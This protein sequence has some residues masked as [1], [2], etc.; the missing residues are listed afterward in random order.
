MLAGIGFR[1][2]ELAGFVVL[3]VTPGETVAN[4]FHVHEAVAKKPIRANSTVKSKAMPS[5][6]DGHRFL[7]GDLPDLD[8]NCGRI[9]RGLCRSRQHFL[10]EHANATRGGDSQSHFAASHAQDGQFDLAIN[11]NFF[12][13][14]TAQDEHRF[15][16]PQHD[17]KRK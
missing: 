4:H 17:G 15:S 3:H 8:G 1:S 9:G 6:F 13:D 10:A 11:D 7:L 5:T 14:F 2:G 16:S 12:T